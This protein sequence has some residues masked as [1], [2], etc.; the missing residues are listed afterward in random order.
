MFSFKSQLSNVVIPDSVTL[1]EQEAFRNS[2]VPTIKVPNSVNRICL[3]AF[4]TNRA[5]AVDFGNTRTNVPMLYT[6]YGSGWFSNAVSAY[7]PDNLYDTWIAANRW[8]GYASQIHRHSEL[9]APYLYSSKV[10]GGA[11]TGATGT[12]AAVNAVKSVYETDWAALSA[13]AD[14]NTFYVVVPDPE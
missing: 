5:T 6:V 2:K 13:T 4:A 1:I 11:E 12:P 3:S 9:E 8:S 14:A 10:A 7:V